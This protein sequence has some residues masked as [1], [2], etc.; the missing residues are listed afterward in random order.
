MKIRTLALATVLAVSASG[1]AVAQNSNP[2]NKSTTSEEN[3]A[4]G[5]PS[6][7]GTMAKDTVNKKSTTTGSGA[8]GTDPARETTHK[9]ASRLRRTLARSRKSSPVR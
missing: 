9:N 4:A 8:T 2:S 7:A 6:G 5:T 1:F 3:G